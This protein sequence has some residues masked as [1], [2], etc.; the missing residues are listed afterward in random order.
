M[1][2]SGSGSGFYREGRRYILTMPERS[3][4]KYLIQVPARENRGHRFQDIAEKHENATINSNKLG[5][6]A[7]CQ[8][9]LSTV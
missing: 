3:A 8:Y 6:K 1:F 7:Y 4:L 5:F 2:R 9:G